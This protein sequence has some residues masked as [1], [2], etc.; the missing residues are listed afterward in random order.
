M[1]IFAQFTSTGHKFYTLVTTTVVV[2]KDVA[3]KMTFFFLNSNSLFSN[4]QWNIQ[5]LQ[6]HSIMA[7]STYRPSKNMIVTNTK[8]KH[9]VYGIPMI[10]LSGNNA[11]AHG[12]S[13]TSIIH[14]SL[15]ELELLPLT[16]CRLNVLSHIM[17]WKILI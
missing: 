4:R 8:M 7:A 10:R 17:Y 6:T 16:H 15:K 13:P 11:K 9:C 3:I 14:S 5:R 2:R 12:W 1:T